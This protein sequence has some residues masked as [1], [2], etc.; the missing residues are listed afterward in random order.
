MPEELIE[1]TKIAIE[2]VIASP[3]VAGPSTANP[4]DQLIQ[5]AFMMLF[6]LI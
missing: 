1:P 2:A 6:I 5:F 4:F 3:E